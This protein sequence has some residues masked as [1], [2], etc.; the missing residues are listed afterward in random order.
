MYTLE[1]EDEVVLMAL[2]ERGKIRVGGK[3]TGEG[4]YRKIYNIAVVLGN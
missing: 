2:N 1:F 3:E 4:K